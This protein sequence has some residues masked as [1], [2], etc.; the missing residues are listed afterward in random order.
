MRALD[1][2]HYAACRNCINAYQANHPMTDAHLQARFDGLHK[3]ALGRAHAKVAKREEDRVKL[4]R[5]EELEKKIRMNEVGLEEWRK[6]NAVA[7][8]VKSVAIEE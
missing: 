2:L 6:K 4:E 5:C 8:S 1:L 3:A 7:V